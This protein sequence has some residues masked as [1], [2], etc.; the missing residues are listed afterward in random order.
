M[1]FESVAGLTTNGAIS[2][3]EIAALQA[4]ADDP[5]GPD[6]NP[7]GYS[8]AVASESNPESLTVWHNGV[9]VV[10]SPA[11]TGGAGTPTALGSFPVYVRLRN[12]VMR[13]T[14]PN[15]STY[16][17]PGA[18]RGVLQRRGRPPL[19]AP[20]LL[21]RSAEPRLCRAPTGRGVGRLAV[22]DAGLDR[23]RRLDPSPERPTAAGPAPRIWR[24]KL[25]DSCSSIAMR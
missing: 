13:G 9:V 24:V 4:A 10:S 17:D 15:G 8:Y 12:Q 6:A 16:A 21:R 3:G 23:H 19:H 11:N 7:N 25:S 22:H 20:N 1:A 5:T 18:V 2:T 14:N